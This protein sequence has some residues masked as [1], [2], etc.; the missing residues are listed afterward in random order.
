MRRP[1][2]IRLSASILFTAL[3]CIADAHAD[4]VCR[5]HACS[6]DA[7]EEEPVLGDERLEWTGLP[8]WAAKECPDSSHDPCTSDENRRC[9]E[10]ASY[11]DGHVILRLCEQTVWV[12]SP[13]SWRYVPPR[14][15]VS[16][17]LAGP[18][19]FPQMAQSHFYMVRACEGARCGP[20]APRRPG[21]SQG[22]V[23]FVGAGYACFGVEDGKRCEK[24]CYAS[25]PK[26]F[27]AIMDC[28]D[29]Y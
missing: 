13:G 18:Q 16:P 11:P 8:Q 14:N 19:D 26:M 25:A 5:R 6:N 24:R 29:P 22:Y 21:G 20:W 7:I 2:Q 23:E 4:E 28:E 9:Y 27:P 15:T 1:S 12:K 3:L 17:Y 10:V